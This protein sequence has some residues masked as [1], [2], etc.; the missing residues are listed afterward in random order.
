MTPLQTL[1]VDDER[2]A[3]ELL[4]AYA[5]KI[6]EL[7]L[8]GTA[9]SAIAAKSILQ[10]KKIDLLFLDIQ[11]PD[12]T[13]LQLLKMLKN[14]PAVVLTTAYS[15]FALEGYELDV[16]DYLLKPIEFE[17]FYR[18]VGKAV[19]SSQPVAGKPPSDGTFRET[20]E[21]YFFVKTDHLIVKVNFADILFIESLR[22]YV[23]IHTPTERI[24]AR[25]ALQRL[26]ELLPPKNFIRTHRTYI[27]NIDKVQKIEGNLLHIGKER[28]PI[29]KGKRE[30]FLKFVEGKGVW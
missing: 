19:G 7:H 28:L 1:I 2:P 22:E 16:V 21:D 4:A 23:R 30:E 13:G 29:S 9:H 5:A 26:E 20:S 8:A 15:E 25:L 24:V 18:A 14:P 27:V 10:E 12:L 3:V 11:M 6:P 17:R